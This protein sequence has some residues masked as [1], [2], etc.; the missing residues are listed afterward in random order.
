[1]E[2]D[3]FSKQADAAVFSRLQAENE[4]L[5]KE[6][7]ELRRKLERM[8]ELLLNAQRAR[9]GQSSEK[10][11]YVLEDSEQLGLFHETEADQQPKE[12]EQRSET[13]VK[14][15]TRKPK[16]TIDELTEGLPVEKIFW[17]CQRRN[18]CAV[19]AGTS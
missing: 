3:T 15:H 18:G 13:R 14:A 2:K 16:R 8:N 7:A 9:F 1:M 17:M 11:E 10:R 6:V 5:K 19:P 12:P 4:T